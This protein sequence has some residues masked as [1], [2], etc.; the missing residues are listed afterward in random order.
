M[1]SPLMQAFRQPPTP[2][3]LPPL[4]ACVS[5]AHLWRPCPHFNTIANGGDCLLRENHLVCLWWFGLTLRGQPI[6]MVQWEERTT[7]F[8][9]ES[10]IRTA[11]PPH[12][13]TQLIPM[14]SIMDVAACVGLD[15]DPKPTFP[16]LRLSLVRSATRHTSLAFKHS[17]QQ[18]L[19]SF[20]CPLWGS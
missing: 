9:C 7:I 13:S 10:V 14:L 4:C 5:V 2:H 6:E 11:K 8:K 19:P 16:S 3:V 17:R 12:K 15:W 18:H 1:P 20:D